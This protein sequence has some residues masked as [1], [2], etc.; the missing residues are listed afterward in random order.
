MSI[1]N[2][3]VKL[4]TVTS[5]EALG[6]LRN[7]ATGRSVP[8]LKNPYQFWTDETVEFL[9]EGWKLVI[10]T[11]KTRSRHLDSV[12]CPDGRRGE[13]DDWRR[14]V[15]F[16]QQPE[17]RLNREDSEAVDRMFGAFRRAR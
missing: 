3:N 11:D 2:Q 9:V 4:T 5:D 14:D 6:L 12:V 13:F 7:V 8:K 1:S 15:Q 17:D 16:S 10:F